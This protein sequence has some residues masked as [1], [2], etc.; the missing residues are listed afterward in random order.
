MKPAPIVHFEI[1]CQDLAKTSK[2][3]ADIFGWQY[4]EGMPNMSMVKNLGPMGE[5]KSDGIAGHI[6]S[7][8]HPPH[9]YVTF[10]AMVDDI[11]AT[12]DQINKAGGSTLIPKQ[13]V[14]GM[15]WFAWFKDPEG[16]ALGLWTSM[17]R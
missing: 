6:S 17:Q 9:Q 5:P 16:N 4:H 8:G 1:G 12:L 11:N 13:E 3:Y 7:L 15:G 2:F 10:Y 14:P